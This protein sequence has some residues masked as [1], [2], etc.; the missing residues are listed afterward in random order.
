MYFVSHV[1]IGN[2]KKLKKRNKMNTTAKYL[3]VFCLFF[4]NLCSCGKKK[5]TIESMSMK[6]KIIT[7]S[8]L[9]N[10]HVVG[11][12]GL[13]LGSIAV[14]RATIC[15]G[16]L[17]NDKIHDGEYLLRITHVNDEIITASPI[18][19]FSLRHAGKINLATNSFD[20]FFM[21]NGY[22]VE[23]LNASQIAKLKNE[24]VDKEV[25]LVCYETGEFTGMPE[26]IPDDVLPWQEAGFRFKSKLEIL[27]ER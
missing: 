22:T 16:D 13:P 2:T 9:K 11:E 1:R 6:E 26:D 15:D 27:S 23:E 24:Y 12:L 4:S 17:M 25:T 8:D 18:L 20:L 3:L 14:I 5:A 21:N 19:E 7:L 10:K